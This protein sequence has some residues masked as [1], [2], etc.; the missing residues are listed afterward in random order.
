MFQLEVYRGGPVAGIWGN[1]KWWARKGHRRGYKQ[2]RRNME[3]E[4]R[5][6]TTAGWRTSLLHLLCERKLWEEVLLKGYHVF[7]VL[8]FLNLVEMI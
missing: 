6:M 4:K 5:M 3:V 2:V 8:I 1:T 7:S